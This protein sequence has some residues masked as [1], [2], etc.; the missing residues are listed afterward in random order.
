MSN[1]Q[2][3]HRI[4]PRLIPIILLAASVG[5]VSFI[6]STGKDYAKA[7]L[8]PSGASIAAFRATVAVAAF[9]TNTPIPT[10]AP[11]VV[12][13]ATPRLPMPTAPANLDN[14]W[15]DMPVVPEVSPAMQVV[16]ARGLALGNNPHAFSKVGD[17]NTEVAFFLTPFDQGKYRLG[18]YTELQT[19]ID[20]FAESFERTSV[21]ARSGFGPSAMFA[22]IWADPTACLA[23]EGPLACEF[24][25]QRPS[26]V[27][28]GLGTHYQPLSKFE[29]QM[30]NVIE[31]SLDNGVVPILATKVDVEGGDRVNALIVYL[32][33]QYDVPLWNFW[34]AEQPLYNKGQPDGIHFTW[35]SNY[36]D[37]EYA[38]RHGWP[39]RN[40]TALQALDAV[41]RA[42]SK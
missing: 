13:T 28:I 29:S 35:A 26:L 22:P 4:A 5:L 15:Q 31:F 6:P 2:R 20:H 24:R 40:L 17:C 1:L 21:A 36:F 30:R 25:L 16:Y 41:W 37:S 9:H 14:S 3:M 27:L 32:A 34:R 33:Q 18:P 10:Q 11:T 12:P 38:L 19:V 39:V 7:P 42:V 8:T 23:S